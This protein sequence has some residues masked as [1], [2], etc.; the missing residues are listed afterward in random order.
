MVYYGDSVIPW[1]V[2]QRAAH[3]IW[4]FVEDVAL[5][6]GP[7]TFPDARTLMEHGDQS[8]VHLIRTCNKKLCGNPCDDVFGVLGMLP[9]ATRREVPVDY[10]Q[11]VRAVNTGVLE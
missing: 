6:L 11:S 9:E 2:Y 5:N 8:L 4:E 3:A 1:D 10:S 7:A